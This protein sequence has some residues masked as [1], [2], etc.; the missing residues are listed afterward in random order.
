MSGS[1]EP[2]SSV[3]EK[4][5][6]AK[7]H[8]RSEEKSPSEKLTIEELEAAIAAEAELSGISETGMPPRAAVHPSKR[9]QYSR[10]FYL[11]LVV[12]FI[13]LVSGLLWWGNSYYS[14]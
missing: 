12:L 1:R 8:A 2:T 11:T 13:F 4:Y 6:E 3:W 10:W 9:T 14:E 7:S 5:V